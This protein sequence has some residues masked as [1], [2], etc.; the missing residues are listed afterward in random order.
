MGHTTINY[1]KE[2]QWSA[3]ISDYIEL[4]NISYVN[5]IPYLR[6]KISYWYLKDFF[7]ETH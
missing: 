1:T 4:K 6:S 7:M 5:H 2:R 3:F